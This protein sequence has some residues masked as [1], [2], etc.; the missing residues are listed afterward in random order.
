MSKKSMRGGLKLSSF[1]KCNGG[2]RVSK[3]QR[4]GE[5]KL[6]KDIRVTKRNKQQKGS[7]YYKDVGSNIAGRAEI[8]GYQD[9]CPPAYNSNILGSSNLVSDLGNAFNSSLGTPYTKGSLQC[10]GKRRSYKK[11]GRRLSK[12]GGRR[13]SKRGGRRLSLKIRNK[14][15]GAGKNS[16][17]TSNMLKRKFGCKQPNWDPDC[18]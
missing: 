15:G 17:Y 13:L 3:S 7:G 12:K 5:V 4:G 16:V 1:K 10:G 14:R 18:V 6:P 8:K 9:C 11:G 2:R